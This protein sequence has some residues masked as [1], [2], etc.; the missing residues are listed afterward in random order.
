MHWS[1]LVGGLGIAVGLI[2]LLSGMDEHNAGNMTVGGVLMIS[3][4]LLRVEA[5][6]RTYRIER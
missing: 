3:G 1:G 5:A 6:I 2:L 4:A